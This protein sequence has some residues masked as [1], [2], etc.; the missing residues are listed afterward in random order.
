MLAPA[1]PAAPV[2]PKNSK[3]WNNVIGKAK[4]QAKR[5]ADNS[6]RYINLFKDGQFKSNEGASANHTF[7][8][9]S[10]LMAAMYA[11]DPSLEVK[12]ENLGD[13]DYFDA[14]V[15][16]LFTDRSEAQEYYADVIERVESFTYRETRSSVHMNAALFMA[17]VP[18]AGV[19]KTT[20]DP[21]LQCAR[22]DILMREEIFV[23]PEARYDLC[24]AEYVV[25]VCTLPIERAKE[26]FRSVGC[27]TADTLE[28]NY[29][30][31]ET[32]GMIG[33]MARRN[34]PDSDGKPNYLRF[35]EIWHKD[36][37]ERKIYYRHYDK[38]EWIHQRD[39]PFVLGKDAFPF[40]LLLFNQQ[41]VQVNDAFTDLHVING[42]R[43][44][45]EK[46]VEFYRS[47]V[48]R[49]V[50]SKVIYDN[51]LI[52]E[53]DARDL[54][55]KQDMKFIGMAL[56]GRDV[57]S[58]VQKLNFTEDANSVI[59][60]VNSIKNIKDEVI[61][62]NDTRRGVEGKKLSATQ[63]QLQDNYGKTRIDKKQKIFDEFIESVILKRTQIDLQLMP[64]EKVARIAGQLAATVWSLYAGDVEELQCQYSIGIAA[65]ST[66]EQAKQKH[67]ERLQKAFDMGNALNQTQPMP[68]VD[69][70]KIFKHIMEAEGLP[71]P[72]RFFLAPL[73]PKIDPNMEQ[74]MPMDP[75]AGTAPGGP[76]ALP[77]APP[78]A[79]G[80]QAPEA[81]VGPR[82]EGPINSGSTMGR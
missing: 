64:V 33:V 17:L 20:F 81:G 22:T 35:Y 39:W 59:E 40:D 16:T 11:R 75:N 15:G 80:G 31:S 71:H 13:L 52:K 32:D 2:A 61:G 29:R 58:A 65:G 47:H 7:A 56:G 38:E 41:Y 48:M 3:Y 37:E 18:G 74:Q 9:V 43:E 46:G 45:Y 66:G 26:F 54:A 63:A 12:P 73:Q 6:K 72:E 44:A 57:S 19:A 27:P 5:D 78:P 10:L 25:Q 23:D 77:I 55:N 76:N 60:L 82:P 4:E 24:Q 69:L 1:L 79:R 51:T 70:V 42:L 21:N 62:I 53:E 67:I 8:D 28:A 36:G 49:C 68:V 34:E 14:L 30:L 50:A